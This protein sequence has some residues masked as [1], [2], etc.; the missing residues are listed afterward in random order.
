MTLLV[1]G[2]IRDGGSRRRQAVLAAGQRLR[3][4]LRRR[5]LGDC[6]EGVREGGHLTRRE[7]KEGDPMLGGARRRQG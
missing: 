4:V 2:A 7:V 6:R 1:D 5:V 3:L